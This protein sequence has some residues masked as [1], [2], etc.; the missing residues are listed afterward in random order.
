MKNVKRH[1]K[2][3]ALLKNIVYPSG[4]KSVNKIILK[5]N[6]EY[7]MNSVKYMKTILLS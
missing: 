6:C 5:I 4:L 7:P 1:V 2:I 3:I